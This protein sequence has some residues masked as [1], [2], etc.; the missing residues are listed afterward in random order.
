MLVKLWVLKET[1][2]KIEYKIC[3][4]CKFFLYRK[5]LSFYLHTY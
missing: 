4:T 3:K 5:L 1:A 2:Y